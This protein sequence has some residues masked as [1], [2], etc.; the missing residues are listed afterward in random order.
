MQRSEP[1][2]VV[3]N[4]AVLV[5]L[6]MFPMNFDAIIIPKLILIFILALFLIP[7]LFGALS[8]KINYSGYL[9]ILLVLLLFVI[10]L[11]IAVYFSSAPFEQQFYGRTG[12]GLGLATHISFAI[13]LGYVVLNSTL[14]S[15]RLIING[16]ALS[17]FLSSIYAITQRFGLDPLEWNSRTNGI[18]GTLGNPNFQSSFAAMTMAPMLHYSLN[19]SLKF[20]ITPISA[21][22]SIATLV[23][24]D[25]TQGYIALIGSIFTLLYFFIRYKNKFLAYLILF[26]GIFM[27][28][29]FLAGMLNKGPLSGFLYK[30]SVESRGDFFRAAV[31]MSNSNPWV[32]VGLDSFG[33]NFLIYRDRSEIEMSD[34][35]HNYFLEFSATG[36]YPLALLYICIVMLTLYSIVSL[37]K[38]LNKFDIRMFC[39][40]SSWLV[41]QMQ[42]MI[43]PGN[44]SLIFWHAILSGYLIGSNLNYN[45]ELKLNKLQNPPKTKKTSFN[46]FPSIFLLIG[47]LTM[48]PLYKTDRELKLGLEAAN[49]EM[50]MKA[51]TSYPESSTKYNTF[52]Q[53]LFNSNLLT[54]ALLMGRA[55]V[56]F[57]PNAVSAWALIFVNPKASIDERLEARAQILKL[58]PLNTEVFNYNLDK[59]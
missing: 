26:P 55:A 12:R 25:S 38:K 46:F 35:A 2:N 10:Q 18:I 14:S 29:I 51:L 40:Y 16:L 53:D 5:S 30:S 28:S 7:K 17:G 15:S 42:S 57:N 34:N 41:F 50:V 31:K 58:D 39:I 21:S 56:N 6:I 48:L 8:R 3:V 36:G 27:G 33:D 22:V 11:L 20:I 54:Q 44:I 23:F 47:L 24:T 4:L 32:G 37:Q 59:N 19:H 9:F 13:I 52:T 1:L 49:A 45:Q 43:S